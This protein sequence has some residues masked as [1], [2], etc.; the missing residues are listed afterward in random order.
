VVDD[1]T[2]ERQ[3]YSAKTLLATCYSP[4]AAVLTEVGGYE[5]EAR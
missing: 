1:E 5:N 3:I 4:F 2:F